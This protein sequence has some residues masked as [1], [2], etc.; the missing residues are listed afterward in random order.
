MTHIPPAANHTIAAVSTP[1][2]LSAIGV[3]RMTGPDSLDILQKLFIP[4]KPGIG[5]KNRKAVYGKIVV[6]GS[7]IVIDDGIAV[8]MRGPNSYTGEDVVEINLHGSPVVLETVLTA[9]VA[10]GAR[11]AAK[12]EFTRRSFLSGKLDLVQAE[13]VIDLIE[14]PTRSAALEARSRL[15]QPLSV[16]IR[17]LAEMIKAVLVNMEAYIDFDEDEENEPPDVTRE[18]AHVFKILE[19]INDKSDA[20]RA[21]RGGVN[22][23]ITGKPNVGKSTLFNSLVGRDR[24][25]VTPFPGTT[26][27][28]VDDSIIL[29]GKSFVIWDT[30][31]IR[32]LPEKIEEEGISRT[33]RKIDESDLVI[34]V[35]DA[36]NDPDPDDLLALQY[37]RNKRPTLTAF[38]KIDLVSSPSW[39]PPSWP[40]LSSRLLT[41]S[42]KTGEG[43]DLLKNNISEMVAEKFPTSQGAAPAGLTPRGKILIDEARACLDRILS[44]SD[45]RNSISHEIVSLEL[46]AS[47]EFLG[48]ITGDKFDENVLDAIFDRFCV[49]K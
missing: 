36:S 47:L 35:L 6:P 38:N 8:L 5:F 33:Y 32:D 11:P 25:I 1:P 34:I 40:E 22:I 12:G 4:A 10:L 39:T 46:R 16:E 45:D 2:G 28:L 37:C 21:R 41:I 14:A 42:A 19:E 17:D 24:V 23:V 7:G 43:V 27:D 30:A 18:L 3:I 26:R 48:Q 44:K 20:A 9:I 13:A 15:D 29:D 49:G 31:G